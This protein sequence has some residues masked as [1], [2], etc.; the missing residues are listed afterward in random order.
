MFKIFF[1]VILFCSILQ[2]TIA[3]SNSSEFTLIQ[4]PKQY[5]DKFRVFVDE[6]KALQSVICFKGSQTQ[7]HE[8]CGYTQG[9]IT[10]G[11]FITPDHIYMSEDYVTRCDTWVHEFLHAYLFNTI[12]N[13]Y[14]HHEHIFFSQINDICSE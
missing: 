4:P 3:E 7:I 13:A 8:L 6:T 9:F 11:C 10:Y 5:V 2:Y 1:S 12:G 14:Q